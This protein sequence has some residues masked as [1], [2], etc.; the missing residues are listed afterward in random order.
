MDCRRAAVVLLPLACLVG[1]GCTPQAQTLPLAP[2]PPAA[3]PE[4]KREPDLPKRPPGPKSGVAAGDFY[5]KE[6]SWGKRTP[7]ECEQFHDQARRAYQQAL[8]VD[9]NYQ[10]AYLGLA[11]LYVA[12]GDHERAVA[13]YQKGLAANPKQ[14]VLEF[15]LGVCLGRRREWGPATQHLQAALDLDPENR[16][17]AN[18][19]GFCLACAGRYDETFT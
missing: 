14:P 1:A 7:A 3:A 13:T 9:P 5:V 4:A 15:E 19:L 17:Y 10:P 18:T 11:R 12:T 6:A 16:R 2:P 8:D